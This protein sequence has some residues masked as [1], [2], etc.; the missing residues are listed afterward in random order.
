MKAIQDLISQQ[1]PQDIWQ[2]LLEQVD[3]IRTEGILFA[4]AKC[5]KLKKGNVTWTPELK[6]S[7]DK[8]GYY[9]KCKIHRG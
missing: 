5:R 6:T 9:Q 7:M 4:D 2:E 8:I 3:A 1:A